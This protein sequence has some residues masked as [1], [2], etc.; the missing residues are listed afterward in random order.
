ML[1]TAMEQR[2]SCAAFR[3]TRERMW[4]IMI[5]AWLGLGTPTHTM[6]PVLDPIAGETISRDERQALPSARHLGWEADHYFVDAINMQNSGG[7]LS[8]FDRL[9]LSAHGRS[10]S[11]T[12]LS[13]NDMD[14]TDPARPGSPMVTIPDGL[15]NNLTHRSLW[16][17]R[18]GFDWHVDLEP[19]TSH[20]D[21]TLAQSSPVTSSP[22]SQSAHSRV[23]ITT[24]VGAGGAVGGGIW[25]PPHVFDRDPATGYGAPSTRRA[26]VGTGRAYADAAFSKGGRVF[27][28]HV[29]QRNQYPL[30]LQRSDGAAL[31]DAAR[32]T[33]VMAGTTLRAG[34]LPLRALMLWQ[35]QDRS[36]DGAQ[37]RWPQTLT[38]QEAGWGMVSQVQTTLA[39]PEQWRLHM[40]LGYG[41]RHDDFARH[42][43]APIVSD[44]ES[45][46]LW[47]ARPR[48]TEHLNRARYDLQAQL[49]RPFGADKMFQI[50]V[51][52]QFSHVHSRTTPTI[53]GSTY[54]RAGDPTGI[55]STTDQP[56]AQNAVSMLIFDTP[57]QDNTQWLYGARTDAT[58][59]HRWGGT[60]SGTAESKGTTP[61]N[62]AAANDYRHEV[63]VT[64]GLDF[65]A[66]GVMGDGQLASVAPAGGAAWRMRWGDGHVYALIRR[67]PDAL[68]YNVSSFLDP[69]R[70]NGVRYRWNDTNGDGVP[71][72]LEKGAVLARTGG[73]YHRL[74]SHVTR[75]SSN[76]FSFGA[77]SPRWGPLRFVLTFSGRW[78]LDRWDVRYDQATQNSFSPTPSNIPGA[79]KAPDTVY[80]RDMRQAGQEWYVLTNDKRADFWLGTEF[81][82]LSVNNR[83]W[84]LNLGAAGYWN[85]GRSS[86]FGAFPD[87]NDPGVID[88]SAADPNARINNA[89]RYDQDRSYSINALG[90]VRFF[91][92]WLLSSALRYRD[93]QPFTQ[94]GIAQA[95]PQGPTPIML[96][97]RG[98]VR[99]TF[100]MSLDMHLQYAT[101]IRALNNLNV[102]A[103]LDAYNL[104][105]SGTELLEDPRTGASYRQSIE[106]VAGRTLFGSITL[107]WN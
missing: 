42:S 76:Q 37:Y 101:R 2:A 21:P 104:L 92:H 53:M 77:M 96:A 49:M 27:V 85:M 91:E 28:E 100:F 80:A 35:G 107:G 60:Q 102:T 16:T 79:A 64:A 50:N 65:S 20:P 62:G 18:P 74:D 17:S 99:H 30:T 12:R 11:Q 29:E 25:V 47:L 43:D 70:D 73:A 6:G 106:M 57:M 90:G 48:R 26:L 32:R 103:A 84:F 45:E 89:G 82:I 68:T 40:G 52:S 9:Y 72:A 44:I 105:G 46:W 4:N 97:P 75:P 54:G 87:R 15:W 24:S 33:T 39:L 58:W 59:V 88:E 8:M 71:S 55:V 3:Y 69:A 19:P 61:E 23:A 51:T 22:S 95:L 93:G 86:A 41:F 78:H 34:A 63:Q 38:G 83:W 81:Q 56:S 10:W 7:G 13:I 36:N 98:R 67:E 66:V 14:V 94:I 1:R 31:T 5:M